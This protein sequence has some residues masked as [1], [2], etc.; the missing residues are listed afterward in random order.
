MEL[1]RYIYIYVIVAA[2]ILPAIASANDFDS[3][4]GSLLGNDRELRLSQTKATAE[5]DAIAA[6]NTLA[7]PEVE[8]ELLAAKGGEKKYNLSLTQSFDWPGVY[9]ARSRQYSLRRQQLMLE[10]EILR[11][12]R[13]LEMQQQLIDIIAANRTIATLSS[14]IDGCNSLLNMLIAESQNGN[15]TIIDLNK[16]K[17]EI[18]DFKLQLTQALADKEAL[19]DRIAASTEISPEIYSAIDTLDCFPLMQLQPLAQYMEQAREYAP[20][21]LAA[22][23]L[24]ATA[25]SDEEVARKS[26]LPS[27]SAGYRLSH[28]DGLLYNGFAVGISLPLWRAGKQRRAAASQTVAARLNENMQQIKLEKEIEA[29]FDS[30]AAIYQ[31][32]TEYG[33]AL[34]T[35]ANRILLNKAYA[36]GVITVTQLILD[37]NYFLQAELQLTELQRQYYNKLAELSRFQQNTFLDKSL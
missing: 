27:L 34:N 2:L 12:E 18:A 19:I 16:T 7:D 26:T 28:E 23:N 15:V 29:T 31:A 37:T 4:V 20:Q 14:A 3:I 10:N 8:F 22:R 11:N 13:M 32:I 24:T 21:L 30:A 33:Q 1:R 36:A 35:S 25:Q 5:S 9:G 6:E 17:I